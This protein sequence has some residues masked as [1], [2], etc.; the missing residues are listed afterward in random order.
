MS[1]LEPRAR[2]AHRCGRVT[3]NLWEQGCPGGL[4]PATSPRTNLR[5]RGGKRRRQDDR[6]ANSRRSPTAEAGQGRVLGVD[7]RAHPSRLREHVGYMTQHYSLYRDL[8][9][10]ENLLARARIYGVADPHRRVAELVCPIPPGTLRARTS[11]SAFRWM[12]AARSVRR[13][14]RPGPAGAPAGRADD[15]PRLREQPAFVGVRS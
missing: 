5:G 2:P 10:T 12:D 9:V 13:H 4:R 15:W 8:T 1:T 11:G 6:F 14:P 7:I 3:K